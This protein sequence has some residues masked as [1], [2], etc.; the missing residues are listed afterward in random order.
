MA[1][2]R[3]AQS[4]ATE[5]STEASGE[6][7]GRLEIFLVA[8]TIEPAETDLA[9]VPAL[10]RKAQRKDG[11]VWLHLVDPDE[12]TVDAARETLD[13]HPLAAADVVSGRQQPKIQKFAE[14]LFILLWSILPDEDSDDLVLGQTYVYIGDGW[15]LTVQRGEGGVLTDLPQLLGDA[16]ENLRNAAMPAAYTIMADLVDGYAKAAADVESDLEEL[17]EQVFNDET[18]EDHRR[19]YKIRKDI[20]R[21]D[22]AVSSI[23]A[24]LRESTEHLEALTVGREQ[25]VP[26]LHDLL[27]D[28]AGT[29][30]LIN[31]QSR[32]LDA[33]LSSHEN[34]VSARQNKDMRTISS[35]AA[36]LALPTLIAGLYG[37]NF[38]N[39]PLVQWQ[40][41]WLAI[42]AAMVIVDVIIYVMFKRRGWL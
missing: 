30:A 41:G 11:F 37:M 29:A 7:P 13:I 1:T 5:A 2:T 16:P 28:A 33:I 24:A 10:V 15:L 42:G 31:N 6:S 21:I 22:R 39:I 38:E 18:A 8:D 19:I 36:L 23:A 25:I 26:Y 35:F 14:H 3:T 40:Y 17:E 4:D 32:A 12:D 20:G 34:N 27:D 9:D